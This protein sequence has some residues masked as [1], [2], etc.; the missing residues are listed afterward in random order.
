M[1]IATTDVKSKSQVVGQAEYPQF[2][3]IEEA[4]NAETYGL[5]EAKC[6]ELINAQVR[7]NEMNKVRGFATGGPSKT[8]LRQQAT[9][10]IIAEIVAGEHQEAV[11]NEMALSSLIEARMAQL[12]AARKAEAPPVSDDEND[13]E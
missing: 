1:K 4:M 5:G 3:T 12:E 2:D 9:S 10:E 11:G 13:E 7:T 6:L 8:V